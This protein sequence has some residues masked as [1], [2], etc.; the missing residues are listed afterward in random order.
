MSSLRLEIVTPEGTVL[1][2][3]ATMVI[4]Q[5]MDGQIGVLPGHIPLVT[6]LD[7][8]VM[9]VQTGGPEQEKKLAVS[10]GFLEISPDNKVTVL[11]QTAELAEEIDVERARRALARAEERLNSQQKDINRERAEIARRKALARLRAAGAEE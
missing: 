1:A 4:A 11:A 3:E 5:T 10:G 6:V 7:T 2:Q 9:R 8:G